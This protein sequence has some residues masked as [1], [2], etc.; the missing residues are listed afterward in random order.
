M[1]GHPLGH[2]RAR[3]V[4]MRVGASCV[5]ASVG[6][7]PATGLTAA[8][9]HSFRVGAPRG[10]A[11]APGV[12]PMG[13]HRSMGLPPP[14]EARVAWQRRV[15]GGVAGNVLVDEARRIFVAGPGR[16]S[17]LTEAGAVEFS[18]A[19][20]FSTAIATA[21]LSDGTRA[22]LTREGHVMGW[23][24]HGDRVL[25]ISLDAPAPTLSSTLL[26]LPDGGLL[27]STDRWL[28]EIDATHRLRAHASVSAAIG[29]TLLAGDDAVVVDP[30]GAVFE[31]DRQGPVRSV[32]HFEAPALAVLV[33]GDSLV[34]VSSRRG[35]ETMSLRTG[36][37][38]M[39]G[40]LEPGGAEP[41]LALFEPGRYAVMRSDGSWLSVRVDAA[42]LP[43]LTPLAA[44]TASSDLD[45]LTDAGGTVAWWAAETPLHIE[46]SPGVGRQ[47]AEVVCAAPVSLVPAGPLSIVAACG[48]GAIWL[49][50]PGD[51]GGSAPPSSQSPP[52][53]I[54][55]RERNALY[56]VSRS[57]MNASRP[58]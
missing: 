1:S 49:I 21:L 19:S 56:S 28:F 12:E 57:L 11:T 37:A 2:A 8:L 16:V 41:R 32:G 30:R 18:L 48:S 33:D 55:I 53:P 13:T 29:H 23:S 50:G 45:L 6:S 27:V 4:A 15:P 7:A 10:P 40:R 3:W 51:R 9:P 54:G 24:A 14:E 47:W 39:L 5:V 52:V 22:V 38:R 20:P 36:D 31:W 44:G 46:T 43:S 42:P 34:S 58:Q 26:P 25:D 17:Q 35:I